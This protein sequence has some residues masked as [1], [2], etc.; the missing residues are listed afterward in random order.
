MLHSLFERLPAVTPAERR[1]AAL[2][3]LA[4][5]GLHDSA[6]A[7]EI[8]D[9]ALGVIEDPRFADLFAPEALA[10]AP[11]AATLGDGRVIAGTADRLCIGP[12][13]VR[14]IDFKTGRLVPSSITDVP[15]GHMA[16]MQAYTAA[17]EVIFPGRR[18]DAALLYTHG[19]TLIAVPS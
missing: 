8:V 7:N 16:Q 12:D 3:W 2:A 15:P 4:R 5:A 19:P 10:E 13:V 17:L 14:V 11:I 6:R 9:A 18:I 1:P